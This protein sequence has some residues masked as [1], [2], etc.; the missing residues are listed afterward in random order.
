MK[1]GGKIDGFSMLQKLM[2]SPGKMDGFPKLMDSPGKIDGFP[3][4]SKVVH[5]HRKSDGKI[6][7]FKMAQKVMKNGGKIDGFNN[8]PEND[9]KWWEN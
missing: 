8:G 9:E 6:D 1:N 4:V 2:D 7:V 5:R 3:K